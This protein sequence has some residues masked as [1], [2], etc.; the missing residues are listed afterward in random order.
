MLFTLLGPGVTRISADHGFLTVQQFADL[1]DVR[2]IG[3]RDNHSVHQARLVI[4]TDM[5]FGTEVILIIQ[6]E[7]GMKT[8]TARM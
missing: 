7:R 2:N 8:A 1:R 3:R 4:D 6:L 5:G